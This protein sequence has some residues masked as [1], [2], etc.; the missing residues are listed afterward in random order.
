[1]IKRWFFLIIAILFLVST[2]SAGTA[3]C[4]SH[5][6]DV[7]FWYASSDIAGYR[8]MDQIPQLSDGRLITTAPFTASSGEVMLGQWITPAGSPDTRIL[9]PG[10]WRFRIYVR[11]SL[12][13]G[14]TDIRFYAINRSA[15]GVETPLYFGNAVTHDISYD[16]TLEEHLLSYAR[17]NYTY[18]NPGDRLIIR[19]NVSTNSALP[20]TV[21]LAVAGN[22]KA[23]MV[24]IGYFVNYYD[25]AT[26]PC[27]EDDDAGS[28]YTVEAS[29][30][31]LGLIGGSMG[32]VLFIK[33]RREK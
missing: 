10:L 25:F 18:F 16:I 13:S 3:Y 20:R 21:S 15:S 24:Q 23:S 30:A 28:D 1:M 12:Q 9:A 11:T 29:A 8:I 6:Q 14:T 17:R 32:G 7:F 33:K 27:P 19:A 26:E 5:Q 4:W 31:A 2:A 22:T